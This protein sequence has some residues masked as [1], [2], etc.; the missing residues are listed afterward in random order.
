M[1][2]KSDQT[3]KQLTE[4]YFQLVIFRIFINHPSNYYI[5]CIWLEMFSSMLIKSLYKKDQWN[6]WFIQIKNAVF[7]TH[8]LEENNIQT[9]HDLM[10]KTSLWQWNP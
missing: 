1:S 9:K 8:T 2:V 4:I 3:R 10:F 5:Y 6:A 7:Y